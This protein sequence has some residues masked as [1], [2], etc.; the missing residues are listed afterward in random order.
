VPV[1]DGAA[2][3]SDEAAVMAVERGCGV[4]QSMTWV[5][6][7]GRAWSMEKPIRA[8]SRK[9]DTV[10]ADLQRHERCCLRMSA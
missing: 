3:S 4:V 1:S 7:D 2:D 6:L 10:K 5:N 8:R 9:T